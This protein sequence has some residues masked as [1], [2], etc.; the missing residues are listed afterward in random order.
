MKNY[1]FSTSNEKLYELMEN[2][3]QQFAKRITKYN[4][5]QIKFL[6]QN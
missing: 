4:L 5:K 2:R 3:E 6:D 1:V